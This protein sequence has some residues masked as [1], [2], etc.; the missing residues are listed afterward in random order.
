MPATFTFFGNVITVKETAIGG[1]VQP[2]SITKE[3]LSSELA[4][5]L[6]SKLTATNSSGEQAIVTLTAQGQQA[7]VTIG[8]G[9]TVENEEL[10]VSYE[11]GDNIGY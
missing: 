10:K 9:L 11:N 7:N 1:E 4:Q 3:D 5:E 8:E 6:D 2:G